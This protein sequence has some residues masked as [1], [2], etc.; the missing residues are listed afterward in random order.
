MA[1]GV[2][3]VASAAGALPEVGGEAV[4]YVRPDDPEDIAG[5]IAEV[6]SDGALA[7]RLTAAGRVR[8]SQ[9][10]WEKTAAETLAFYEEV[11]G[12]P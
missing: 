7:R 10:S 9:Y 6:L 8:A 4:Q 1:S 11:A 5:R 3:I 12:R 2:P